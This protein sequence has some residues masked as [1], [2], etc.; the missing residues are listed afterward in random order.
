MNDVARPTH[1]GVGAL[2]PR[3][4]LLFKLQNPPVDHVETDRF[5]V[6]H[7]ATAPGG[8]AETVH[9]DYVEIA[10]SL[11]DAFFQNLGP[12][13]HQGINRT[14]DDFLFRNRSLRN[15]CLTHEFVVKRVTSGSACGLRFSS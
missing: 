13:V 9:I 4:V 1:V 3:A 2:P 7:R 11:C 10:C 6:P 8:E 5:R 12:F 15:T 14:I